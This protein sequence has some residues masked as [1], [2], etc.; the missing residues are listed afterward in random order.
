M[1]AGRGQLLDGRNIH[2][3]TPACTAQASTATCVPS[4]CTVRVM[5]ACTQQAHVLSLN[6]PCAVAEGARQAASDAV[7]YVKESVTSAGG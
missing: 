7:A 5:T 2:P 3:L 6:L 1:P 4:A